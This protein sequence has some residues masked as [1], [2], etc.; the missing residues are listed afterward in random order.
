M[1]KEQRDKIRRRFQVLK[2][3]NIDI[4]AYADALVERSKALEP[5]KAQATPKYI[6]MSKDVRLLVS[7]IESIENQIGEDRKPILL[8]GT[9]GNNKFNFTKTFNTEQERE[10]FLKKYFPT[11]E[12]YE[13]NEKRAHKKIS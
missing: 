2:N 10:T 13:S 1:K 11:E 9:I 3:R 5:H 12:D 7:N 4:S 8:I 6:Q